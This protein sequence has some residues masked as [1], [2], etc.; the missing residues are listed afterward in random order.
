MS[1][2]SKILFIFGVLHV[3]RRYW[4]LLSSVVSSAAPYDLSLS[5]IKKRYHSNIYE[6]SS[7][8]KTETSVQS[9]KATVWDHK[10]PPLFARRADC[11]YDQKERY[12]KIYPL[13]IWQDFSW[14][15]SPTTDG[16]APRALDITESVWD[17][18]KRQKQL[19]LKP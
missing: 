11:G 1:H 2:W 14:T 17:Y 3:K 9:L 16:T 10:F 18:M 19:R 7:G 4:F 13:K 5:V 12:L 15:W 6:P 8:W